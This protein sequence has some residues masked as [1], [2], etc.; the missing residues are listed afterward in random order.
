M[1]CLL[2]I[3]PALGQLHHQYFL[4]HG[5]RGIMSYGHLWWGRSLMVLGVINGGLGM[6]LSRSS[7]SY[8]VAYSVV[9]VVMYLMYAGVKA[10]TFAR[11]RNESA[12]G[13]VPKLSPRRFSDHGDEV[14]MTV[15]EERHY[16]HGK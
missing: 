1:V 4:K 12:A 5:N 16:Q 6:Q 13:S 15:Y 7:N 11:R 8:L 10:V 2:A 9:A 14:P 3:Q